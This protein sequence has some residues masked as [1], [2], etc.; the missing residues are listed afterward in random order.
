LTNLIFDYVPEEKRA[1]SLAITQ[2]FAG[3]IGFLTT[4]AVSPLVTLI[5]ANGNTVLGLPVYA[6]QLMS[7][8]G[9]VATIGLIVY[10]RRVFIKKK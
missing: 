5:Q 2:A 3:A 1:D 6:Q 9:V 4:L 7:V 8:F 10:V